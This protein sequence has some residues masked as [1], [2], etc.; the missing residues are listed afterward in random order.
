MKGLLVIGLVCAML[1]L[2]CAA[3][4]PAAQN[5]PTQ[6]VGAAANPAAPAQ[7]AT[8]GATAKE[9]KTETK[10]P[11]AP[12]KSASDTL[13]GALKAGSGYKVVYD[14]T[15]GTAGSYVMTQYI[16]GGNSRIDM[17]L[18]GMESR[19]YTVSGKV[20]SC[21]LAGAKWMCSDVTS[22]MGSQAD[23]GEQLQTQASKY[24]IT[25]DG[26]ESVASTTATCYKVI[27]SDGTVRYCISSDGVPLYVKT[28]AQGT[29]VV[30]KAKSYST[31][32]ADADFALPS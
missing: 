12:A 19:T 9:N 3:Q 1:F 18:S 8:G 26:T 27:S 20:N 14:V 6:P 28:T 30:M 13:L 32:V 11:E 17:A 10:P 23:L 22:Q 29:E 16:K 21:V 5:P 31:G 2:G 7:P 25:A 24:T 4:Q 15:A